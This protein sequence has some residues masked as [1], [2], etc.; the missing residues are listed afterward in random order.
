MKNDHK[1]QEKQKEQPKFPADDYYQRNQQIVMKI[2]NSVKHGEL[3]LRDI[4]TDQANI[5]LL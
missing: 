4:F 2:Q 3:D 1:E 5:K